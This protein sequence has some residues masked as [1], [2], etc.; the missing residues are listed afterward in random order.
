MSTTRL[1]R[2]ETIMTSTTTIIDGRNESILIETL[3]S[4]WK[5]VDNDD[6]LTHERKSLGSDDVPRATLTESH[7]GAADE[8]ARFQAAYGPW[9][10]HRELH[11]DRGTRAERKAHA[12]DVPA[13]CQRMAR[14]LFEFS[15]RNGACYA[16]FRPTFL[17]SDQPR[18]IAL[19]GELTPEQRA[20]IQRLAPELH[21]ESGSR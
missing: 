6:L 19:F 9:G 21:E 5:G 13:M 15:R 11:W 17:N 20:E 3:V 16:V 12:F 18:V 2:L 1:A 14:Y 10:A 7:H 8:V 4:M